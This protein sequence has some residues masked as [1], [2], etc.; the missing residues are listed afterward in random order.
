MTGLRD[1]ADVQLA[2]EHGV[3]SFSPG[4]EGA[5]AY[6]NSGY[7]IMGQ[8]IER[9]TGKALESVFEERI[10]GPLG[11]TDSF[12][13]SDAP[14]AHFGLAHSY[15]VPPFELE[16]TLWNMSQAWAAGG[17]ISTVD[18]MTL[19]IEALLEGKLFDD[20]QTLEV[21]KQTVPTPMAFMPGYGIGLGDKT[22]GF[23]GHGPF[24]LHL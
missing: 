6:S 23:W 20:L 7:V 24:H 3:P 18:D 13:W 10:F 9:K 21:M 11:M 17:V 16:T 4:T 19:Y 2:V 8:I 14:R 1:L 15:L 12:L 5:W 22:S